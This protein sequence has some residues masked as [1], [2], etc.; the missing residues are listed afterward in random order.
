MSY[1]K[2]ASVEQRIHAIQLCVAITSLT[3]SVDSISYPLKLCL[4][5]SLGTHLK[6][7]T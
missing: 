4:T 7:V 6:G 1:D 3:L 2:S 5:G